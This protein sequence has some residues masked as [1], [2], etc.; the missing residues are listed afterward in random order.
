MH[1]TVDPRLKYNYASWYLLGLQQIGGSIE[2]NV[3]PFVGLSYKD[4][5]DYNSGF[6]FIIKEGNV[7]KKVF[8]FM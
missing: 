2:Y 8:F 6:G 4:T 1:I 5:P 3:M 7:T